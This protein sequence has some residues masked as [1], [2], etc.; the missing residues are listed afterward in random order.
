VG[1]GDYGGTAGADHARNLLIAVGAVLAAPFVVWRTWIGYQQWRT[2][3]LQTDLQDETLNTSLISKAIELLGSMREVQ[4]LRKG[5]D[6]AEIREILIEKNVE[7]RIGAL[8]LLRRIGAESTRYRDAITILMIEYIKA[9]TSEELRRL[10]A[11][12]DDESMGHDPFGDYEVSELFA[13]STSDVALCLQ[14]VLELTERTTTQSGGSVGKI[15]LSRSLISGVDISNRKIQ[16]IDF[17]GTY[18]IAIDFSDSCIE[19][20][21]LVGFELFEC[22]FFGSDLRKSE[23]RARQGKTFDRINTETQFPSDFDLIIENDR[24]SI[25]GPGG[26]YMYFRRKGE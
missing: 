22:Q 14:Y 10:E 6:G 12:L 25:I 18:L 13:P 21:I 7:A 24:H 8:V 3:T 1:A 23:L 15:S 19:N 20:C 17:S 26:Q 4:A 2:S 5:P 11:M 9:N 16:N